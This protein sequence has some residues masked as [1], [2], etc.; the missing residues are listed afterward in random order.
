MLIS[1]SVLGKQLVKA[2]DVAALMLMHCSGSGD[3]QRADRDRPKAPASAEH[4]PI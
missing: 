2:R 3:S 1:S 4:A